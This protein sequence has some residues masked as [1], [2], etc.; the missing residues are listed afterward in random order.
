MLVSVVQPSESAICVHISPPPR[1]SPAH[2][3]PLGDHKAL[4]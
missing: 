2:P 3:I 4:S 1:A